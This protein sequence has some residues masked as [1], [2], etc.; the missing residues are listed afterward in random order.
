MKKLIIA[1]LFLL[2]IQTYA[3]SQQDFGSGTNTNYTIP[4]GSTRCQ[5]WINGPGGGGGAG[6]YTSSGG[7]GGSGAKGMFDVR[8]SLG[9]I[10]VNVRT[11]AGGAAGIAPGGNGGT[12]SH[13]EI[14]W[15]NGFK[16]IAGA[17]Q[18]GYG[19]NGQP[20]PGGV[21][22]NIAT[23]TADQGGG[24]QWPSQI[25]SAGQFNIGAPAGMDGTPRFYGRGG[26]E[27]DTG[28]GGKGS[29]RA[30]TNAESGQGGYVHIECE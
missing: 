26:N 23:N 10:T 22:G 8:G 13:T 25:T 18:G 11:Y 29:W 14:T 5:F 15:P 9:G 2:P 21:G 16:M 12:S 30:P 17:A 24:F 20:G 4:I 19:G 6:D 28:G 27:G 7:G 3:A 1:A